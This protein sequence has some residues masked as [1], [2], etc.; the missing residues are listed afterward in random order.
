MNDFIFENSCRIIFGKHDESLIANEIKRVGANKVLVVYGSERIRESGLLGKII[1][2]LDS[3][4]IEHVEFGGVVANPLRS[5]ATSGVELAI[6]RKIDFVLAVGGG[7]VID[8]AK[9]IAV[10]AVPNQSAWEIFQ[11]GAQPN[12]MTA[13]PVGAVLTLPAA[14]SECSI[15]SVIRDNET[16]KKF[17][18]GS[19]KIRPRFAFINPEYCISLPKEQIGYGASDIFAHL[20][21]RYFSPQNNVRFTDYLLEGAMRAMI[22]I[23]PKLYSNSK[24]YELWAEFC[25]IGTLAHNNM[26]D[27]GRDEQDWATHKMENKL[28]SGTH[29]IAH[30][31]GLAILFP[32]WMK[33][34]SKTKPERI[35]AFYNNVISIDGLQ[36]WYRS[37]GLA[38]SLGE[39]DI[40]YKVVKADAEKTFNGII[41][42][43]YSQLD[44]P[45]IL[46]II[47]LA[48]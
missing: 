13:L 39:L 48:K 40:D 28:L 22:E 18:L 9:Y 24:S 37:I 15:A 42:G 44:L 33:Y 26:L 23:A 21:E 19:E 4:G 7:S 25:I 11:S 32:A 46:K 31:A 8:A 5:H 17:A 16:G 43:K 45:S 34:V 2:G 6:A 20:L 10:G 3:Q 29:N 27:M 1:D 47:E 30:G 41:L 14:G 38:Q 12:E 35:T 36:A